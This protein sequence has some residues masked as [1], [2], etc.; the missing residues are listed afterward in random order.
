MN[1]KEMLACFDVI[2]TPRLKIRRIENDDAV[3]LFKLMSDEQLTRYLHWYP[4]KSLVEVKTV[5]KRRLNEYKT[6]ETKA[7]VLAIA[8]LSTNK[9]IGNIAYKLTDNL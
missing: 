8:E 2:Y 4:H 1:I 9:V 7:L 6:G 3:Q 5:V